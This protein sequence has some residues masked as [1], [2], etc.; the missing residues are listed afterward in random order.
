MGVLILGGTTGAGK[1]NLAIEIAERWGAQVVSADAMTVYR[2]M[3]IGTA[4]PDKAV[5]ARVPHACIDVRDPDGEFSVADFVAAFEAVSSTHENTLVVGGTPFYLSALVRPLADM[6]AADP[7]VRATLDAL[8]DPHGRLA[9]IDPV[10]AARLHPNDRVRIM[11]ALE[12]HA[13]TGETLS[14]LHAA[15]GRTQAV[16]AEC[17]WLDP[18]DLDARIEHRLQAMVAAGYLDEV[19]GLLAAGWA[20]ELKPMRSFAYRYMVACVQ[21]EHDLD[22]AIRCTARDSRRFARKQRTWA[23]GMGW[24]ATEPAAVLASAQRA[25]AAD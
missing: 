21:G 16:D 7:E 15:G 22:E 25:F 18:G 12:V 5:R 20:P 19:S 13:I 17:M 2:G 23:R 6:P 11:R 9:E 14:A 24:A 4:K 1:T 8:D 3:D 10:T